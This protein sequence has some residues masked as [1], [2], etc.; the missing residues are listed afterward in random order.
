MTDST[1]RQSL[2][3][4]DIPRNDTTIVEPGMPDDDDRFAT[5]GA[6]EEINS[7]ETGNFGATRLDDTGGRSLDSLA[8]QDGEPLDV[9]NRDSLDVLVENHHDLST[10]TGPESAAKI[11]LP[12]S[13]TSLDEATGIPGHY[14]RKY[15][16]EIGRLSRYMPH[17]EN[18]H[19]T[20]RVHHRVKIEWLDFKDGYPVFAEPYTLELN[21]AQSIEKLLDLFS[22]NSPDEIDHRLVIVDEL[23]DN[24]VAILGS[25][26]HITPEMFEEHLLNSGWHAN[27]Y[28]DSESDSWSTM[29]LAKPY[30]SIKWYRPVESRPVRPY[31]DQHPGELLDPLI[32]PDKW[33]ESI[34][35]AKRTLHSIEP[36]TNILRQPWEVGLSSGDF[37]AWEERA[38]VW[39]TKVKGCY[40][41]KYDTV[42]SEAQC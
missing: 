39:K 1:T 29:N 16:E 30:K 40:V 13:T 18:V 38:T 27:T 17:L 20:S 42:N 21:T 9:H 15:L 7:A 19:E 36:L 14:R 32:I 37:S 26:L 12:E 23:S 22:G 34:S 25:C 31:K 11:R 5:T 24:L 3:E 4:K 8:V 35:P 6:T 33:E 2:D 10:I 41:G 28:R